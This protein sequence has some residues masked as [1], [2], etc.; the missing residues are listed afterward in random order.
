MSQKT[1]YALELT[2]PAPVQEF[3]AMAELH[4]R[5]LPAYDNEPT[6]GSSLLSACTLFQKVSILCNT[7][8]FLTI[9]SALSQR[10]GTSRSVFETVGI[11]YF[12]SRISSCPL[13]QTPISQITFFNV[14]KSLH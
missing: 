9:S 7:N 13:Y 4:S 6:C 5:A 10:L 11:L 8:F 2:P 1:E 3:L 12:T 14:I